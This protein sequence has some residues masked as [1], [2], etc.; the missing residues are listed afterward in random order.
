[1]QNPI[2]PTHVH[3]TYSRSM[4][5]DLWPLRVQY[6]SI[7]SAVV[8]SAVTYCSLSLVTVLDRDVASCD[9]FNKIF[10]CILFVLYLYHVTQ[11][12]LLITF[13]CKM[14]NAN[15]STWRWYFWCRWLVIL[16]VRWNWSNADCAQLGAG[17]PCRPQTC[18][19]TTGCDRVNGSE[20][21][22]IRI[23]IRY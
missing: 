17:S 12:W 10:N 8:T 6:L 19:W 21:I 14:K 5:L 1:M 20:Y 9:Y 15:E 13:K 23:T 7:Q 16:K 2:P 11:S 18:W 4:Q 3:A 22:A